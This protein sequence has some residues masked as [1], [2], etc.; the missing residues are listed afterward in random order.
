VVFSKEFSYDQAGGGSRKI[1]TRFIR[2]REGRWE[3]AAYVWNA[4]QTQATLVQ[5]NVRTSVAVT[6]V[7]GASFDHVVPSQSDCQTC[8]GSLASFILGF[9]ELQLNAP[10]PGGT[11]PQLDDLA[12]VSAFDRGLPAN[13]AVIAGDDTTKA[14]IGY[15]QGNC[16]HCHNATGAFDMAYPQFLDRVVNV[17]GP[18]GNI[19]VTPGDTLNSGLFMRFATGSMPPLGVQFPD[20]AARTLI[21]NWILLHDFTVP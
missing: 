15:L 16:V 7:N 3:T 12:A 10:L 13:P 4:Q 18:S 8:H 11:T 17:A 6:D 14:V 20:T 9:N 21:R 2:R 5:G 1:E 19:V